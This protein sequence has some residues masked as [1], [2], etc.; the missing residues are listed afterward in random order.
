MSSTLFK[1]DIVFYQRFLKANGFYPY[2]I[3]G[4]WGNKTNNADIA[5]TRKSDEIKSHYGAF[6]VRSESNIITLTPKVQILVRKFLKILRTDHR[7]DVRILSGTRTYSEQNALYSIGRTTQKNRSI[8]TN[9][10]GGQSNHNFGLAWDI[11][12]FQNGEYIKKDREYKDIA[13]LV[14][15]FLPNLEWGGNWNSF[16]DFPHYQHKSLEPTLASTRRHFE[17]GEVYV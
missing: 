1:E 3:D 12:I 4:K 17:T 9:A 8:V 14:L 11:G 2:E 5:F 7:L 16:K 10:K 15:P 6:D 13:P